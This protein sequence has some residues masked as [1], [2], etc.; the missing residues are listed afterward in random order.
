VA[1]QPIPKL[2]GFV[3]RSWIWIRQ[4][5][6]KPGFRYSGKT[7]STNNIN[8]LFII[9]KDEIY[10]KILNIYNL[11]IHVICNTYIMSIGFILGGWEE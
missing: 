10:I 9:F 4:F 6:E 5:F 8:I 7:E 2:Q 11:Y 1:A 3:S